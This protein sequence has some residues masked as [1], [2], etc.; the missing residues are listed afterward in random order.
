MDA[1]T[2]SKSTS[3]LALLF[4]NGLDPNSTR[5]GEESAWISFLGTSR[6]GQVYEVVAEACFE[7]LLLYLSYGA[8][9]S[10]LNISGL[11]RCCIL[12]RMISGDWHFSLHGL[13]SRYAGVVAQAIKQEKRYQDSRDD[14]LKGRRKRGL[15]NSDESE[16]KRLKW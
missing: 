9:T 7:H 5:M 13:E 11:S 8:D 12:V 3:A 16:P 15:V 14:F 2:I 6:C 1:T 4:S 10:M